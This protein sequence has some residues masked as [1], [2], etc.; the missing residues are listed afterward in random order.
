MIH[1]LTYR[2][3]DIRKT[4]P[5]RKWTKYTTYLCRLWWHGRQLWKKEPSLT[6][7][8]FAAC[9]LHAPPTILCSQRFVFA[10]VVWFPGVWRKQNSENQSNPFL[11]ALLVPSEV[12][13]FYRTRGF[14]WTANN[15]SGISDMSS[16]TDRS[17]L[18]RC[19][20]SSCIRNKRELYLHMVSRFG[21]MLCALISESDIGVP[22]DILTVVPC[23]HI[24]R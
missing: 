22:F 21:R 19:Y 14:R 7:L 18:M 24:C 23:F 5:S 1:R 20:V 16:T 2:Q 4:E 8:P 9:L 15:Q 3:T 6:A 11:F 17:L 10:L 12:S 13:A